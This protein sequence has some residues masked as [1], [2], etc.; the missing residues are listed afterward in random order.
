MKEQYN[1]C[2]SKI[3]SDQQLEILCCEKKTE[4]IVVDEVNENADQTA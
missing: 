3:I 4:E 1:V 2:L